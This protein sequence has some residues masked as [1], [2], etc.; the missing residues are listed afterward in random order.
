MSICRA[1]VACRSA[2]RSSRKPGTQVNLDHAL[3]LRIGRIAAK[4]EI[5]MRQLAD[6]L[7]NLPPSLIGKGA[8][9]GRHHYLDMRGARP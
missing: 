9:V 3:L 2:S 8:G 6:G 7:A 4:A 1:S 5:R